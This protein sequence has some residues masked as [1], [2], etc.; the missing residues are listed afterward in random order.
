MPM[1]KNTRTIEIKMD[2]DA[3]VGRFGSPGVTHSSQDVT[4][5][6]ISRSCPV[7]R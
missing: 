2:I 6:A 3:A 5:R 4:I 7:N 1:A